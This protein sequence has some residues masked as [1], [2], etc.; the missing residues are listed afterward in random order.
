MICSRKTRLKKITVQNIHPTCRIKKEEIEDIVCRVLKSEGIKLP[1]DVIFVD[2]EF[3][4]KINRE[5]TGRRKTT[6]VLSF[7]I[8]EGKNMGVDYPS[9]GDIYVS[10]DQAKRQA[11]EYGISLKEEASRLV[12]HGLLHLLRYDHK[13]KRQTEIMKEKEEAYLNWSIPSKAKVKK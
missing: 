12:I 3:M 2:D 13:N 10:L 5:F 6:D 1:V 9:L 7:G 11:Q 8:K 4:E